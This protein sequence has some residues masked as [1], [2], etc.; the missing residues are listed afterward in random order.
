MHSRHNY[1]GAFQKNDQIFDKYT[2]GK[3]MK[4]FIKIAL[5]F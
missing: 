2:D 5:S 3:F 4:F 1:K